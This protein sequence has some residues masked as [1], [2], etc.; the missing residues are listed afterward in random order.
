MSRMIDADLLEPDADYDDGEYWGYS[1]AQIESAPTVKTEPDWTF[2]SKGLPE[3]NGVYLV[4]APDYDG[5][6][7]RSKEKHDGVMFSAFRNGKWGIEHGYYKRPNCVR[8]WKPF[9][10]P[11]EEVAIDAIQGR[12]RG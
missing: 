12:K 7:S 11:T 8:A 10:K 3:K 6:S 5:G 4:Y 9:S 1:M 2:V